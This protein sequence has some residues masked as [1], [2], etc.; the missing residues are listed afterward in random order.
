MTG[1]STSRPSTCTRRGLE[2][3]MFKA[4]DDPRVTKVG[5]SLRRYSLDELP[6]LWNVLKG[7]MS[8]VGPRP[9]PVAEGARIT[10]RYELRYQVRPGMTGPW[11]VLGRSD[12]PF[13]DMLKLDYNYVLNWSLVEDLGSSSR[14]R[15][16]SSKDGVHIESALGRGRV[17]RES[18]SIAFARVY[19]DHVWDVYGYFAYRLSSRD[20]AEDL[21]QLTFERALKAWDRFDARRATVGTWLLAIARN[22]LVDHYRRDRSRRE[23]AIGDGEGEALLGYE[24]L[25][26]PGLGISPDLAAGLELLGRREREVLALRFGVTSRAR[27]SPSLRV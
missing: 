20:D 25:D 17:E 22:L 6:Q 3:G 9:L 11:Q 16:R 5:A 15:G 19:D 18:R 13:E 24:E 10:T 14:R 4:V 23:E 12:I 27:R 21:T 2:S 1:R 7:D 8:L 26:Q